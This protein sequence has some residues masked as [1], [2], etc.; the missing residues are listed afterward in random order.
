MSRIF[1]A[2]RQNGYV[3]RDIRDAMDHWIE[4]IGVGPWFYFERVKIDYFR[5]RGEPSN[6]EMSIALANSGDLQ[7]ELIQQRNDAPSM[8]N[9]FLN[10]GR[11]GLQHVA[12]W[13]TDYQALYDRALSLGYKVGHEG[14]IGGEQGR[15]AYFDTEA[16]PGTVIELS[17]ISGAKGRFFEFVRQASIGWDGSDAIRRF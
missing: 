1:G 17:D 12:Y 11:E 13:T 7:I 2:I 5:H 6:V 14:Q 15:F 16:H 9:E 8:Y 3:V 10:A 4:V